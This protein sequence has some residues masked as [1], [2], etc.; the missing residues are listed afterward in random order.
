MAKPGPVTLEKTP[1]AFILHG[2]GYTAAIDAKTG[3]FTGPFTG[4]ELLV[5]PKS[6]DNCGGVQL[7]GRERT[8]PIFS[9]SCHGWQATSVTAESTPAGAVVRV[10]GSYAEAR[11]GYTFEFDSD[12]SIR[13]AYAFA[14]TAQGACDARQTGVVFTLPADCDTLTWRRLTPWSDYPADHIGRAEG[15]AKAF[16][17]GVPLSGL[18]GPRTAPS[19][20]W[21]ADPNQFGSNDFRSTKTH[22]LEATILSPAGHGLRIL[23]DGAGDI[24][25]WVDATNT[26]LLVAGYSNEGAA[27][28]FNEH[29]IPDRRIKPGDPVAG[30]VRLEVR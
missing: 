28:F 10:E 15:M 12:G 30:T 24:R 11:G 22:F 26:R 8:V 7:K 4:P 16:V 2:P 9:D 20:S 3:Q 27:T 13:V 29:V 21:S 17:T 25:A 1:G 5:L 19:W 23:G 18:A 14:V 6:S